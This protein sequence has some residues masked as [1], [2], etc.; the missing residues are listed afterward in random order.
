MQ[1]FLFFYAAF[2]Y[3]SNVVI[4]CRVNSLQHV[5]LPAFVALPFTTMCAHT[6]DIFLVLVYF[7]Y[8]YVSSTIYF[9]PFVARL[10]HRNLIS[11]PVIA[12]LPTY[13]VWLLHAILS[14]AQDFLQPHCLT[15]PVKLFSKH[16]SFAEYYLIFY[17]MAAQMFCE[18]SPPPFLHLFFF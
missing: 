18:P 17:F 6:H 4:A 1:S 11:E 13:A 10:G 7:S 8:A 5:K 15:K 2:K 12:R 3:L 14:L 16:S 9:S